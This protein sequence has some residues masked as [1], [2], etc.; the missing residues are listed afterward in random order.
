MGIKSWFWKELTHLLDE[1]CRSFVVVVRDF[2]TLLNS[3]EAPRA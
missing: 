3:L 1:F 2:P